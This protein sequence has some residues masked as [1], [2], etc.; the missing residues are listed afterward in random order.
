VGDWT[1]QVLGEPISLAP[2]EQDAVAA[3]IGRLR[4]LMHGVSGDGRVLVTRNPSGLLGEY[5]SLLIEAAVRGYLAEAVV[6]TEI[7]RR[8]GDCH[9]FAVSQEVLG[10][11]REQWA[12]VR[13]E[14]AEPA[15]TPFRS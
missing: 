3:E 7:V 10:A 15:M 5:A 6:P 9:W 13:A 12:A 8:Y 14:S 2:D 11:F 1:C 4:S